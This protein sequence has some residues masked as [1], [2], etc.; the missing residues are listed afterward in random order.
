MGVRVSV[1]EEDIRRLYNLTDD[2]DTCI[3]RLEDNLRVLE[4]LSA[5][6][7]EHFSSTKNC[8]Y[9]DDVD[10][11]CSEL[12]DRKFEMESLAFRA[13]ALASLARSRESVVGLPIS[14]T[15]VKLA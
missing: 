12:R 9:R 1:D 15:S 13:R 5:F 10:N 3:V 7:Q 2:T 11:F 14:T 8:L 6:Y 4:S